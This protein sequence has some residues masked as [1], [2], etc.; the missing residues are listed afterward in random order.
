MFGISIACFPSGRDT[1]S[2]E[3]YMAV[4]LISIPLFYIA[5]AGSA[6][7]WIIGTY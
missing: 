3:L 5:G 6:V 2:K 7:F 1:S 4:G